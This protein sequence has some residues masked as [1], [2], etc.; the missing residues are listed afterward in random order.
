MTD[1]KQSI[2]TIHPEVDAEAFY[3]EMTLGG[4]GRTG[5]PRRPVT[6]VNE[7]PLSSVN[8]VY[9]LSK[10]EAE[11]LKTDSRVVDV[12]WGTFEENNIVAEKLS[13]YEDSARAHIKSAA[14]SATALEVNWGLHSC[15][16]KAD[17]FG[18]A[19]TRTG[20][21]KN[22]S[23]GE[24]VD[25]VI[26]DSG[27]D[28]TH[29]EF[30]NVENTGTRIQRINWYQY[31]TTPT[32]LPSS[33]YTSLVDGHGTLVAS[34]A[35]G[36]TFGWARGARIISQ[37][38]NINNDTAGIAPIEAFQLL[39]AWHNSKPN[40]KRPTVVN[41]SWGYFSTYPFTPDL[42]LGQADIKFPIRVSAIDAEIAACIAA[43]IVFV[44]AAGNHK[45]KIA[46][47]DEP[48]YNSRYFVY[49][50]ITYYYM[51]GS[52][53]TAA[54]GVICVG[55]SDVGTDDKKA[56][57]SNCGPRVDIYAP[58]SGIVGA[59]PNY[60]TNQGYYV[61][62]YQGGATFKLTRFSGTT[63]ASAQVAGVVACWIATQRTAKQIDASNWITA[64]ASLDRITN[65]GGGYSDF[66]SLQGS[67]NKFLY[68][69]TYPFMLFK[70]IAPQNFYIKVISEPVLLDEGTE[71]L[72]EDGQ[73]VQTE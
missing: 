59:W 34:I 61:G 47:P 12:M 60:L 33:Y 62:S 27:V 57:Y 31:R 37:R 45:H 65:T 20:K 48:E 42:S 2:V 1:Y 10:D 71:L 6:V 26:Q 3:K 55:A 14:A 50:G 39:R 24:N 35:G 16:F 67:N 41:L 49:D 46:N 25:L 66:T 40:P 38:I 30:L 52:S 11:T 51:R 18:T 44:G 28:E 7:M 32:T 19:Q 69:G 29:P 73:A 63:L 15:N 4:N 13:V 8:T 70:N 17:P 68:N 22:T 72:A 58:G 21:M 56:T 64:N 36:K 23:I 53:P 9:L 54:P 5:V 43:G